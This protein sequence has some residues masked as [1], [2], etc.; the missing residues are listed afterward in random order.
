M[1]QNI[2]LDARKLHDSGMPIA[3]I[4]EAIKVKYEHGE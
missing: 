4:R 3:Q 1:C 2:A